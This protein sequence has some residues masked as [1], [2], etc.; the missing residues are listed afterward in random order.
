MPDQARLLEALI[1]LVGR[2]NVSNEPVDLIP[3]L[4]DSYAILMG[5]NIP[6][7]DFV[8][9]PET[10]EQVQVLVKLAN[11]HTMPV[12]PRS[13]GVNIAGS[14][15]P[16]RGGLILDLKRMNRI[17]EINEDTMTATI[18]PGVTW[19]KLRREARKKH[20]DII[21]IG[22]PYQTSPVGNFLLTNIT[23]YSTKY[24]ADRAVTLEVVLP[25]GRFLRTGSQA[26]PFGHKLNPYFRYAYGPDLTGLFRGSLGNLGVVTKMV[27]RLRPLAELEENLIYGFDRLD[28]ALQALKKIERLEI[29]RYSLLS[30]RFLLT[31]LL[32]RPADLKKKSERERVSGLFT[33]IVMTVGLGGKPRQV[34]LYEEMTDEEA[35]GLGGR[36]LELPPD[37]KADYD[38]FTEGCS[39]KVLRMYAPFSGFAAVI[40]CVP[41]GRIS[42]VHASVKRLVLS[43]DL[44]DALTNDPL[45]PELI[46]VP[47]DRASTAYVEHEVLFDPLDEAAVK[48][49]QVCLR[50]CYQEIVMKHGAV[51]TMPN[52]S[53][54]KLMAPEYVALLRGLKNLVDPNGLFLAGGP[55]S[56]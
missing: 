21:P 27:I 1:D 54:F 20:L 32:T 38:E 53:L 30:N 47:Y 29:S 5:R 25:D 37:V 23:P 26:A 8:V 31:H 12:Y 40:G 39:Q 6:L 50:E 56:F 44:K 36:R 3:Y 52:R 14:A 15:L 18:E 11:D 2:E 16:Y 22:G 34:A 45:T 51:H 33:P 28:P 19:A 49:V 17:L 46:V 7:P 35:A 55:Y 48:K 4:R 13:F 42:E 43:H 10:A 24:P 41:Y 9:L